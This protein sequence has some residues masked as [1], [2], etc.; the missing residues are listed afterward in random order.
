MGKILFSK[1]DGSIKFENRSLGPDLYNGTSG[2]ALFLLYLYSFTKDDQC[3]RTALGAIEQAIYNLKQ[4]PSTNRF[5]FFSG[6]VGVSYVAIKIGMILNEYSL[7]EKGLEILKQLRMD[8][9]EHFYDIIDGNAGAIPALLD[10]Y[11]NMISEERLY[12]LAISLGNKLITS[13]NKGSIG[14]SWQSSFNSTNNLTGFAH[15]TA[16]IG[17]SLLELFNMTKEKKF[18]GAAQQAFQYENNWFSSKYSS[19]S[20]TIKYAKSWCHGAPGIGLSRL[21]AYK[22]LKE[23]KYLEDSYAA[24]KTA[25]KIITQNKPIQQDQDYSFCHGLG[26]ICELLINAHVI[27]NDSSYMSYVYDMGVIGEKK[28][29]FENSWPCGILIGENPSLMLGL[30]GIGYLY[31]RLYDLSKVPPILIILPN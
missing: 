7:I 18:L 25:I 22:I 23:K 14:W 17:Y 30:A 24:L 2:I 1:S 19:K 5:G 10:I 6:Q 16:G 8:K 20:S 15:G 27:L 12:E 3:R 29:G 31:L 28:Y 26:G 21:R 11:L 13:A 9:G 4:I